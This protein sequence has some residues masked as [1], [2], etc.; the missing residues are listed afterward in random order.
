MKKLA[1]ITVMMLLAPLANAQEENAGAEEILIE[2]E[3][4]QAVLEVSFPETE[5]I[6]GQPLELRL[7]VLVP[8]YLPSPPVWPGLEAPNLLI[9]LPSRSTNPR[10]APVDGETWNGVSRLYRISPMVPG[11]FFIPPQEVTVTY[12]DPDTNEPVTATLNTPELGFAG[13]LPAGAENLDPFV[14]AASLELE[15]T[16]DG[17]PAGMTP[18]DSV[19]RTIVAKVSGTSPMFL[20]ALMTQAQ[21]EGVAAYPDEPVMTETED[22]GEIG[23]TRTESTT[24]V[25]EGGGSGEVPPVTVEWYNL[26]TETVETATVEGFSISVDGPPAKSDEPPRD[27]RLLALAGI[28]GLITVAIVAVLFRRFR[29]PVSQHF[30]ERRE[31]RLASE[32]HAW[33]QLHKALAD[34][35]AAALRPA[36]DVWAGRVRGSD[37]RQRQ[38]VQKALIALGAAKYGRGATGSNSDAWRMLNDALTAARKTARHETATAAALP[39]LNQ[40]V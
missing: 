28:A 25:A 27:W 14:A 40:R 24:F 6:P 21:I 29:E 4:G 30:A 32:E 37:P 5:A 26:E 10:S 20:P 18:G 16:V 19:K 12:A 8:T 2:A 33:R 13:V 17:D 31:A 22:R 35:D 38:G 39:G 15:Q 7:T 34:R 3:N 9:R 36:L 11:D 1:L 23:G